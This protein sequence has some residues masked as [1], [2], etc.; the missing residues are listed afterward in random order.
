[1]S[2]APLIASQ[3]YKPENTLSLL[4]TKKNLLLNIK[5]QNIS[6]TAKYLVFLK[7]PMAVVFQEGC[8]ATVMTG[9]NCYLI[10]CWT[11]WSQL[12]ESCLRHIKQLKRTIKN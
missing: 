6:Q 1:M 9:Y 8:N 4:S 10:A 11:P 12:F 2:G 3:D 5:H 7:L